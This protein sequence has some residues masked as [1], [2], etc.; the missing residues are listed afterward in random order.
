MSVPPVPGSLN[1]STTGYQNCL[2]RFKCFLR[3]G[4]AQ[5]HSFFC[6]GDTSVSLHRGSVPLIS[7]IRL[8]RY[9]RASRQLKKRQSL[10]TTLSAIHEKRQVSPWTRNFLNRR[11][12]SSDITH[13]HSARERVEALLT[14]SKNLTTAFQEVWSNWEYLK[15]NFYS[16]PLVH[17]CISTSDASPHS[18]SCLGVNS[19]GVN[20][21]ASRDQ[22]LVVNTSWDWH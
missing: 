22:L 5:P 16:G 8:S 10:C 2:G 21:P 6:S 19:N 18:D 20:K 12:L 13:D 11:E 7:E 4:S 14:I 15:W 3:A 1:V 9:Q 17:A